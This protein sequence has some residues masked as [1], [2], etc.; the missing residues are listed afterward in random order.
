MRELHGIK[1]SS[2]SVPSNIKKELKSRIAEMGGVFLDDL[3]ADVNV[4]IVGDTDTEKYRFCAK[5]RWDIKFIKAEAI[6]QIYDEWKSGKQFDI[7]IIDDH[8][9]PAFDG[10]SIC[11]SRLTDEAFPKSVVASIVTDQGG[12]ITD[13]LLMSTSFVISTEQR[14]KRFDKAIE[15]GI[16]VVHP[17]WVLDSAMRGAVLDPQ[18][19]DISKVE[20]EDIG[21]DACLVWDRITPYAD[22]YALLGRRGRWSAPDSSRSKPPTHDSESDLFVGLTFL[23]YGFDQ[24]QLSKLHAIIM[25]NGGDIVDEYES[26]VTNVILPSTM[27][28]TSVPRRIKKLIDTKDLATSNEWLLERSLYYHTLKVDSWSIP[29]NYCNLDFHLRVS[30]TGFTGVEKL[31]VTKLVD[32]IGC[33]LVEV[34]DSKCDLLC[35]NLAT[36]GLTRSNSPKLYG[37]QYSDILATRPPPKLTNNQTKTKINAAKKWGIPVMSLGYLWE[38]SEQGS[39]PEV[40][41]YRWCI[42]GP[43]SSMASHNF[44][45]YARRV[46]KGTFQTQDRAND[47]ENETSTRTE[48]PS[49]AHSPHS[50]MVEVPSRLPS[51]KKPKKR[52]WG[53]LVGT[54]SESQLR[55]VKQPK[56]GD[57][58]DTSDTEI[59]YDI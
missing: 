32:L 6:Y 16:P 9:S 34:F 2:T 13:S 33:T 47:N 50:E 46:T 26:G 4:L 17:R 11:I 5:K 22:L 28:F 31:H 36:I 18:Y 42:F 54:A 10:M 49:A 19:Y 3:M 12:N 8:L 27:P 21:K 57:V 41:D 40:L 1:F 59:G 53:R 24:V 51:P 52:S 23:T 38:C 29:R 25:D 56:F 43:R 14:G 15:W 20:L 58:A 48:E 44:M 55:K 45:E 30:I 35:V 7:S 39:L 37:Y